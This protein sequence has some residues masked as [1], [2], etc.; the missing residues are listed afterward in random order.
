MMKDEK[1]NHQ[2]S[3]ILVGQIKLDDNVYDQ[4]RVFIEHWI[5]QDDY[6]SFFIHNTLKFFCYL[7]STTT[8][9]PSFLIGVEC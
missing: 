6:K 5:E 2:I 7:T 4:T 9:Y 3:S 8:L 1:I